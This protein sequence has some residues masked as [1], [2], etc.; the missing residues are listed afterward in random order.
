VLR[1][2]NCIRAEFAMLA[3]PAVLVSVKFRVPLVTPQGRPAR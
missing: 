2:E 3:W 1:P